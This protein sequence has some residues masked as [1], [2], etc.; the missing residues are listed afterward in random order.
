MKWKKII[1][2]EINGFIIVDSQRIVT[3]C[4]K[5]VPRVIKGDR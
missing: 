5:D 3:K 4:G 2:K 1:G